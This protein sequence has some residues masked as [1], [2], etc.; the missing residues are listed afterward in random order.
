M[1]KVISKLDGTRLDRPDFD[2]L[3]DLTVG[4]FQ[5][6]VDDLVAGGGRFVLGGFDITLE[7]PVAEPKQI[8]VT[9]GVAVGGEVLIDG[10]IVDGQLISEGLPTKVF[11][12]AT[13][14]P[15]EYSVWVKFAYAEGD[16][17]NRAYLADVGGIGVERVASVATRVVPGWSLAVTLDSDPIPGA[18]YIRIARIKYDG[19]DL[20]LGADLTEARKMLFEGEGTSVGWTFPDFDRSDDRALAGLTSLKAWIW[21]VAKR[22]EE[23]GGQKW[24]RDP[25]FGESVRSASS[26][27]T[28]ASSTTQAE[29]AHIVLD[30]PTIPVAD[31]IALFLT[32]GSS[33]DDDRQTIEFLPTTAGV[34][35]VYAVDVA[36]FSILVSAPA[37]R[38]IRGAADIRR[39]AG[40]NPL[41]RS[42][43][44][45]ATF[46]GLTFTATAGGPSLLLGTT[47]GPDDDIT[48]RD[49]A[50]VASPGIVTDALF[51]ASVG[52]AGARYRFVRCTFTS[53]TG[54]AND[55]ILIRSEADVVVED[56]TFNGGRY[57]IQ[58]AVA[59]ASLVVRNCTFDD[60]DTAIKGA[61]GAQ[62]TLVDGGTFTNQ[63]TAAIDIAGTPSLYMSGGAPASTNNPT[64]GVVA[65]GPI[66]GASLR[67]QL[68]TLYLD[69]L[70]QGHDSRRLMLNLAGTFTGL[71]RLGNRLSTLFEYLHAGGRRILFGSEDPGLG[72]GFRQPLVGPE[73]VVLSNTLAGGEVIDQRFQADRLILGRDENQAEAILTRNM[74]VKA[75]VQ[76]Y[77]EDSAAPTGFVPRYSTANGHA[78]GGGHTLTV[79]HWLDSDNGD[80]HY[81]TITGLSALYHAPVLLMCTIR[82]PSGTRWRNEAELGGSGWA[83]TTGRT[84][85]VDVRHPETVVDRAT[86]IPYMLEDD[87]TRIYFQGGGLWDGSPTWY[88]ALGAGWTMPS[89][90]YIDVA[91]LGAAGPEFVNGGGDLYLP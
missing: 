55:G 83:R 54:L 12:F 70:D 67:S 62:A 20:D 77:R 11:D 68:A 27:I 28:V 23:L 76:I 63:A 84:M 65:G 8:T 53:G 10:S 49:C 7:K 86:L 37:R 75:W 82:S 6:T 1:K 18:E 38:Y 5:R 59:P 9:L 91:I 52:L 64:A 78:L 36:A 90:Y 74:T 42:F 58:L 30:A 34:D 80:A 46:E 33:G 89:S 71:N 66:A 2:A 48:F 56:C 41:F 4:E 73:R 72:V 39:V 17:A 15:G 35:G 31:L 3:H 81:Y 13:V 61:D 51:E 25:N 16:I 19:G 43:G 85:C 88:A 40:A 79:E 21:A 24:Q 60:Q 57:G 47:H 69:T 26:A 44:F 32:P 50:F 22:L 87:G 29:T 14:A 45:K